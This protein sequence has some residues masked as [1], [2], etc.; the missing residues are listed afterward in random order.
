LI[1]G[2]GA[3]ALAS[4]AQAQGFAGLGRDAA[5]FAEV[6]PGRVL[7]FPGDHGAHPDFR[8]EW[9]Y[10]TANLKDAAGNAYGL[11]WTLF[12]QAMT[13]GERA[14]WASQQIWMAHAAVTAADTHRFAET[15]SRGG[16]GTAGVE[17]A[18]LVAWIDDWQLR[19]GDGFIPQTIAP[20]DLAASSANFSYALK[21]ETSQPLVLQGNAGY[22]R[23]SERG[24]ASYYYSQPFYR[25]A[26][27]ITLDSKAIDVTGEAWL[28]R[29]WSSQP[30]ASDQTGWDW[31]SL[32]LD[33]GEK[34]MLFRLLQKDGT[35]YFSGN[36]I[37]H[38]G[39]STQLS[40]GDIAIEPTAFTSI[41]ERRLPT[42]WRVAV[43][44]R[45]LR[46]ETTPLNAKSWMG[47]S[48]AYWE[49]PIRF[50]GSRTGVGYLEMTGY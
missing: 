9:W 12:R 16:V 8:I 45:D 46:I 48:F 5:G 36:W 17:A 21:L 6:V 27:R 4:A 18:P 34:L 37:G 50:S 39:V 10:V 19:G 2:V 29:E 44:S 33:G 1:A 43:A 7:V 31:L 15:F 13:P 11:Q 30:L 28:D 20:L 35:S 49:G 22:S 3:C 23:K 38:D 42:S 32:H 41:G 25:A 14:G 40:P 24:Q 26:G 47:T